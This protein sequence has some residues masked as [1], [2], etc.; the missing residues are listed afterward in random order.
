[1]E[2]PSGE[3]LDKTDLAVE[4]ITPTVDKPGWGSWLAADMGLTLILTKMVENKN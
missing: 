4:A 1:M 2:F 3:K